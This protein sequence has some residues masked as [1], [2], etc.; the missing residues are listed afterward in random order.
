MKLS[1]SLIAVI[2]ML[3]G[4]ILFVAV[5]MQNAYAAREVDV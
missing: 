5:I 4:Y 1:V 3:A 2:A